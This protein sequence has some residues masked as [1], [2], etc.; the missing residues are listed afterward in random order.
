[1]RGGAREL[2]QLFCDMSL[3]PLQH[4]NTAEAGSLYELKHEEKVHVRYERGS[5]HR[6]ERSD[7]PLLVC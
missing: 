6:Y 2:I 5:S 1:M 7:Q 4:Q 3:L